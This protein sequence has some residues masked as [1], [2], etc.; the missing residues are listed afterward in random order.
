MALAG[1]FYF[2]AA[3][4]SE[5]KDQEDVNP[6]NGEPA[7]SATDKTEDS[8]DAA[9]KD[10]QDQTENGSF[11]KTSTCLSVKYACLQNLSRNYL[12]KAELLELYGADSLYL[13]TRPF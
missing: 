2:L 3:K 6:E 1:L 9:N 8:K 12:F 13:V 5:K 4:T 10:K 11:T 7:S